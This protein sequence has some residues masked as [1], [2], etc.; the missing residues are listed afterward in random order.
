LLSCGPGPADGIVGRIRFG[1]GVADDRSAWQGVGEGLVQGTNCQSQIV[2][3]GDDGVSI[4][5]ETNNAADG[6]NCRNEDQFRDLDGPV[7][8][9]N[10][11][12]YDLSKRSGDVMMLSFSH[13]PFR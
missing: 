8:V 11:V 6:E 1:V 4:R 9:P 13:G 5:T 10:E 7:F 12:R 2:V 3:F